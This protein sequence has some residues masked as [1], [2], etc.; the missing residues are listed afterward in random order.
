MKLFSGVKGKLKYGFL[1]YLCTLFIFFVD[2]V[3]SVFTSNVSAHMDVLS[4][5]Y[6][7][8]ASLGHAALFALLL[9]IVFYIPFALLL[10]RRFVA[11]IIYATMTLS[12]QIVLI[13]DMYVFDLYKFHINGFVLELLFGGAAT[14]IFVFDWTLYLSFIVI[15]LFF[16]YLPIQLSVI[17]SKR[18]YE[19]L[20]PSKIRKICILLV[21]CI[22][23]SHLVYMVAHAQKQY[24]IQK[25]A[26]VL[27]LF[28]PLTSNTLLSKWGLVKTDELDKVS[29]RKTSS[30]IQYPV[31]PLVLS[32]SIPQ[33]NVVYLVIDSWNPTTLDSIVAPNIVSFAKRGHTFMNHMSSHCGTRGG[34]FGLFFGVSLTYEQE[35]YMEQKS[36]VLVDRLLQLGYHFEMF[37]SANFASPPLDKI[38][39]KAVPDVRTKAKGDS[40]MERDKDITNGFIDFIDNRTDDKPFFS[41]VFYDLPHAMVMPKDSLTEFLPSWDAPYYIKLHN[42]MDRTP[43]FNLYKNCV[44]QTDILVGKVLDALEKKGLLENT[45]IVVTG[46]HGQE[47][48]ENQKNYW[49]HGSNYSKWQLQV[50]FIVYYP[51]IDE[52]KVFNHTTTHYDI[53]PSIMSHFFGIKNPSS[54][55]SMGYDLWDDTDRYPH[56]VGNNVEYGFVLHD[57]IL[58]TGHSGRMDIFDLDMNEVPR[59]RI[60]VQEL[61]EAIAKKN[62]F[63]KK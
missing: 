32:D 1:L 33:Y 42:G 24:S 40:P 14:E 20:K 44:H 5:G 56:V 10:R 46:D 16:A 62:M 53:S 13:L 17:I 21:F 58:T 25:S 15:V 35:F 41:F 61:N 22:V 47:F 55:Y 51:G 48:N 26:T 27:P 52:G 30:D 7:V 12:T 2:F 4:W 6:F 28:F 36:P 60:N 38:V 49:G 39:F 19:K 63:Y 43:F 11:T 23:A 37:P 31:N 54:D 29:Y 3:V 9:Q 8:I 50:P 18:Y 57:L 34:I 45:I 59:S